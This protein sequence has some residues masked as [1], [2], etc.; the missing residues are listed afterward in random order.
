MKNQIIMN[1]SQ[2]SQI[3]IVKMNCNGCS[4][5][6]ERALRKLDSVTNVEISLENQT[7]KV[8]GDS[9][10]ELLFKVIQKTGKNVNW[11]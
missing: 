7:V 3:F 2:K 5:A 10:P 6:V 11:P 1:L 8:Y 9:N 4:A